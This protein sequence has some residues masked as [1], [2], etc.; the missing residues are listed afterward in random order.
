MVATRVGTPAL[1]ASPGDHQVDPFVR[2]DPAEVPD[3]RRDGV[4]PVA[5]LH[6]KFGRVEEP[7]IGRR[8]RG[9]RREDG[10]LVD[11]QGKLP[12]L[13]ADRSDPGARFDGDRPDRLTELGSLDPARRLDAHAIHD[14]EE[15][16][17]CGVEADVLDRDAR[18]RD[19]GGRDQEGGRGHIAGHPSIE[20]VVLIPL[21]VDA[22]LVGRDRSPE[23]G[24]RALRVV[25]GRGRLRNGG[26][27]VGGH[28]LPAGPRS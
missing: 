14:L 17:P 11:D 9:E 15:V 24:Q 4:Q 10:H 3:A 25:T 5:F 8:V 16:Q 6:A 18:P 23:R 7:G 26:L 21:D 1:E 19:G 27:A 28:A 13:D 2:G 22:V 12:R 20:P